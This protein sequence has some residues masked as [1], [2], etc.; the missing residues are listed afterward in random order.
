MKKSR[1]IWIIIIGVFVYWGAAYPTLGNWIEALSVKLQ[2]AAEVIDESTNRLID[3]LNEVDDATLYKT[4]SRV[5]FGFSCLALV[6]SILY[7][8]IL[9]KG[10]KP[11]NAIE[12][13]NNLIKY[14]VLCVLLTFYD[15]G[16][17]HWWTIFAPPIFAYVIAYPLLYIPYYRYF[18]WIYTLLYSVVVVI[19]EFAYVPVCIG[20]AALGGKIVGVVVTLLAFWFYLEHRKPLYCPKCKRYSNIH[21]GVSSSTNE[22]KRKGSEGRGNLPVWERDRLVKVIENIPLQEWIITKTDHYHCHY[23]CPCCGHEW[24]EHDEDTVE[25]R[26]YTPL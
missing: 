10:A 18:R 9:I 11:R 22:R 23:I 14:S 20:E 19:L 6:L 3:N 8:F 12:E 4:I 15:H 5:L 13:L 7:R 21:I 24:H 16:N 26:Q 25:H 1:I 17:F 2:P